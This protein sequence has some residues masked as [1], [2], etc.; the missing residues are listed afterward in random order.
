MTP[1]PVPGSYDL[2]TPCIGAPQALPVGS[3]DPSSGRAKTTSCTAR[4]G[5]RWGLL[6]LV[7]GRA[8]GAH[9]LL[10]LA[11]LEA[12]GADVHPL[13]GAVDDRPDPLD[14]RVPPPVGAH[15]RMADALPEGRVLAAHLADRCHDALLP[16]T[17]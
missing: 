8:L 15:V 13:R 2:T 17:S 1:C 14:V 3:V 5:V 7:G 12:A 16:G 4:L 9:R 6:G 11:G 10:D